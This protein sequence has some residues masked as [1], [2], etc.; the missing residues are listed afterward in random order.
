MELSDDKNINLLDIF[1]K[2][3]ASSINNAFLHS[4]INIKNE[5]LNKTYEIIKIRYEETID[6]LRLISNLFSKSIL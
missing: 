1:A 5:E 3:A 6:T 2:Q 4:L